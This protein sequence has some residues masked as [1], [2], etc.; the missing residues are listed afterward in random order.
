MTTILTP[1][2]TA[3]LADMLRIMGDGNRLRII[4]AC[5]EVER[6]VG[7]LAAE[8]GLSPSLA[9]HHLRLL[10]AARILKARREGKHVY[11]TA[12]D[13]HVRSVVTDLAAHVAEPRPDTMAEPG[14]AE[15]EAEPA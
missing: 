9:S 11:Y 7:E 10:R 12:A 14:P 8:L 15:A 13:A 2:Q 5:L 3:E 4:L 1:D 6:P